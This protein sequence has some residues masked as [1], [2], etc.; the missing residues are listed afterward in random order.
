[1]HKAFRLHRPARLLRPVSAR[2]PIR[3]SADRSE[4][5][6]AAGGCRNPRRAPDGTTISAREARCVVRFR[7]SRSHPPGKSG[8]GRQLEYRIDS[9]TNVESPLIDTVLG[10][11]RGP[12]RDQF[13]QLPIVPLHG[14]FAAEVRRSRS[15]VLCDAFKDRSWLEHQ[16]KAIVGPFEA[17]PNPLPPADFWMALYGSKKRSNYFLQRIPNIIIRL[18]RCQEVYV[19][20]SGQIQTAVTTSAREM[21]SRNNPR[22]PKS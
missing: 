7:S 18:R 22:S 5:A 6:P 14:S 1:M 4:E 19:A 16:P 8:V 3:P 20:P 9:A 11:R 12:K 17:Y 15:I 10:Q 13:I 2:A 21:A